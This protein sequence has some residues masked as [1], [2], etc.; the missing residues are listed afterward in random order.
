MNVLIVGA[1]GDIG[2]SIAIQR[3][4]KGDQLIL[5]FHSNK[6]KIEQLIEEIQVGQILQI[7]QA[8]LSSKEGIEHFITSIDFNVDVVI[9]ANGKAQF[10]LF[11]ETTVDLIEEMQTLHIE[12]PLRVTKHLLPKMIKHQFG[13]IIFISSIWGE[14]GASHEVLYSTVKG[15]QNSFVKALAKEVA[16]SNISVNAISPG[17]IDT[18][19]NN[20]LTD[21]EKQEIYRHIPLRRPGDPIEVA[22]VVN[23]L[24]DEKTDFL[25]GQ[26]LPVTGGWMI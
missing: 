10:G 12:A 5:H 2:R 18:K 1:S 23:Y 14:V 7:I 15:A 9:F 13:K 11:Q 3:A 6:S 25:N 17:F 20:S 8:D 22:R 4:K 26:I 16:L 24:L 21:E 19:M